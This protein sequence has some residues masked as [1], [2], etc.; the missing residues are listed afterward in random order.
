MLA[1]RT[2]I[3]DASDEADRAAVLG[4]VGVATGVGFALGPA[5]GGLL[6][7]VSL[8]LAA[9]VAT[10]GSVLSIVLVWALLPTVPHGRPRPSGA[11]GTADNHAHAEGS[12]GHCR[13]C[14]AHGNGAGATDG[15]DGHSEGC[16][17]AAGAAVADV[18]AGGGG[19]DNGKGKA[20]RPGGGASAGAGGAAVDMVLKFWRV[21]RRPRVASLL[22][23][24]LLSGWA[25]ALFQSV[26]TLTLKQQFGMGSRGNGMV[27]SYMGFALIAGK[28][29]KRQRGPGEGAGKGGPFAN[30]AARCVHESCPVLCVCQVVWCPSGLLG[31]GSVASALHRCFVRQT[32]VRVFHHSSR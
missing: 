18:D 3:T 28:S 29:H 25:Q 5:V 20:G 10:A 22:A 13:R 27:L 6:S 19:E 21:S 32:G 4:Y 17:N 8:Q 14:A 30:V 26:F 23:T 9:W 15:V 16:Q 31:C 2:I 24:K 1:A 11:G 12:H 7:G